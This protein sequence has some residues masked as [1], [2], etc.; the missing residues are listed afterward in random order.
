VV[1]GPSN[2]NSTQIEALQR[3][4]PPM[5]G[6]SNETKSPPPHP[7]PQTLALNNR[8]KTT[9]FNIRNEQKYLNCNLI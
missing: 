4:M 9:Y 3:I 2:H 1:V 5:G 8:G 7:G 6:A